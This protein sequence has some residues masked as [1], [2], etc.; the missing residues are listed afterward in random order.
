MKNVNP[1][2]KNDVFKYETLAL[3]VMGSEQTT[4]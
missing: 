4:T 1:S 2:S 3:P